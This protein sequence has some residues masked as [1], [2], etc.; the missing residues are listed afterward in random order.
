RL[1]PAH[2]LIPENPETFAGL[3]LA[4]TRIEGRA[5]ERMMVND[6]D[7]GAEGSLDD[8]VDIKTAASRLGVS[9]YDIHRIPVARQKLW[10]HLEAYKWSEVEAWAAT[11]PTLLT[12]LR[13][14]KASGNT[15]RA[16]REYQ[17]TKSGKL[18]KRF[19]SNPCPRCGT[20]MKHVDVEIP[21][22]LTRT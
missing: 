21:V 9:R 19:S 8:L 1:T 13:N 6:K 20:G 3:G 22:Q 18:K 5:K 2:R 15:R 11:N 7:L 14:R 17:F 4:L 16:K 10:G 12:E